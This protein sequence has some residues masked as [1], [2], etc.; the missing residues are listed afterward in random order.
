[1]EIGFIDGKKIKIMKP[2]KTKKDKDICI[3]GKCRLARQDGTKIKIGEYVF[4]KFC[5]GHSHQFR[6]IYP[7]T[8]TWNAQLRMFN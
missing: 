4:P 3:Y 6:Q 5:T 2:S 1:M 7:E 8:M